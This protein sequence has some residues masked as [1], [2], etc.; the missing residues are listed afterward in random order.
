M[1]IAITRGISP[2]FA[3][4]ELTHL[5]RSPIDLD[6]A[7]REHDS[8]CETLRGLGV[9]IVAL[10]ADPTL[11]DCV[12]VEDTAVVLPECAV[13]TRPGAASRRPETAAVA[14]AVR[15]W[16]EMFFISEP[17]T[18]DGGDVLVL[19]KR[20]LVGGG[21]RSNAAGIAQLADVL[22]PWGYTVE[23]VP[24]RGCLHLKSAVTQV[25][26]DAVLLN[27]AWVDPARFAGWRRIEVDPTEPDAANVLRVGGTAI[28]ARHHVRTRERLLAARI[29]T[30]LVDAAEVAKAEGAVT[31]CSILF[32]M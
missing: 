23:A 5:A 16:R 2:R 29:E 32:D 31:C 14:E 8:Y 28:Y 7:V 15:P 4:C 18:L 22:A 26:A 9:Q 3:D 19:G 17:G 25:A 13:I 11:P 24:L 1:H 12:F 30:L 20:V 21:G 27:P 6:Q 10:P